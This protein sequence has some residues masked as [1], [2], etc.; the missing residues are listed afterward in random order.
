MRSVFHSS[1]LVRVIHDLALPRDVLHLNLV[2]VRT[3]PRV[4]LC[5]GVFRREA[6]ILCGLPVRLSSLVCVHIECILCSWPRT[7][8]CSLVLVSVPLL[9][10][11]FVTVSDCMPQLVLVD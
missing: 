7:S 3:C 6:V 9:S 8:P 1:F 4:F 10:P 2:F 11:E 5:V